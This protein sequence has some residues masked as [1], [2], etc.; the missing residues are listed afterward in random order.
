MYPLFVNWYATFYILENK[1]NPRYH[2]VFNLIFWVFFL[3]LFSINREQIVSEFILAT[4]IP[5]YEKLQYFHKSL[6]KL[7]PREIDTLALIILGNSTKKAA[8]IL[9]ISHRTAEV[10]RNRAREKLDG[11][12]YFCIAR[13]MVALKLI[14]GV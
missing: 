3:K 4:P 10:Y 1:V 11:M 13:N 7:T 14:T 9:E 8:Q 6:L 5:S 2:Q 12:S